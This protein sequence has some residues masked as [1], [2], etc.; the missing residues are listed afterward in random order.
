MAS[1]DGSGDQADRI[2]ELEQ[3]VEQ[4]EWQRRA[5]DRSQ[6]VLKSAVP[7]ETRDHLRAAVREQLLA[8]RSLIDHWIGRL[9]EPQ[10]E[11]RSEREEIHIE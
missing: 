2:V 10:E 5:R 6:A 8:I 1:E 4:L 9:G 11:R 7:Q 3:R